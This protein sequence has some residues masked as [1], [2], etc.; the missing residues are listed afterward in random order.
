M[1]VVWLSYFCLGYIFLCIGLK[2]QHVVNIKKV[3]LKRV[4]LMFSILDTSGR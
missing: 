1:L 4:T 2:L 3:Q